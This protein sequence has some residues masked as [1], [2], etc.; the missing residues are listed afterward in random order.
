M[1]DY[2]KGKIYK[3]VNN[4]DDE[5]YVG[6]TTNPL[7]KRKNDHRNSAKLR[8]TIHVFQHLNTIGW[9]N[10]EI[11]LIENYPCNSKDELHA[12]ERYWIDELKPT[13]N[14]QLPGRT[15]KEWAEDNREYLTEKKKQYYED[16]KE[17]IRQYKKQYHENNRERIAEHDKQRYEAN[18]DVVL[19][20]NKQYREA[21]KEEIAHQKKVEI[22]CECGR[23]FQKCSEAQHQ[24]SKFHQAFIGA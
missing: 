23:S 10:V 3:L 9:K 24:R 11:I 15:K 5:I 21:H 22:Q 19:A 13:L 7:S 1:P 16:N 8:P 17:E 14:K 20:R 2:Q 6:S 12:R 4:V 18:K